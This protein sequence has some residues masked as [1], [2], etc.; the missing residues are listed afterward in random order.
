MKFEKTIE[1][2]KKIVE[3]LEDENLPLERAVELYEKGMELAKVADEVLSKAEH[4]VKELGKT[5]E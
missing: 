1:E 4:R 5:E 3:E 2:L